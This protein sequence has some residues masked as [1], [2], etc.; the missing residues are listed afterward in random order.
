MNDS[1]LINT[2]ISSIVQQVAE[3][4]AAAVFE[5]GVEK[6]PPPT[7][8]I[9]FLGNKHNRK[10]NI[11]MGEVKISSISMP[12][13]HVTLTTS[14]WSRLMS[15]LRQINIELEEIE[16]Y[17]RSIAYRAHIGDNCYVSV[18]SGFDCVDIRHFYVPYGLQCDQVC[19]SCNGL[20]H[21]LD[22]WKHLLKLVPTIHKRHPELIIAEPSDEENSQKAILVHCGYTLLTNTSL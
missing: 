22:M 18:T 20:A 12:E 15:F 14:R 19:P 13:K 8:T 11:I 17:V 7:H 6:L 21:R 9:Y 10:L 2:A 1:R 3:A 16:L 4:A 5:N